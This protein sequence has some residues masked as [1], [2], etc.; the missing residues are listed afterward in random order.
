MTTGTENKA[1][2]QHAYEIR[3]MHVLLNAFTHPNM[4]WL[5]ATATNDHM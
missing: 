3:N 5:I 1:I 4:A 2:D